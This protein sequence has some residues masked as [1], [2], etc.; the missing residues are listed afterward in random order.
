VASTNPREFLPVRRQ[1]GRQ[2]P[3]GPPSLLD[4]LHLDRDRWL[5]VLFVY[6]V[7][8]TPSWRYVPN[9]ALA[10]ILDVAS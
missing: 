2:E 7:R 6:A 9:R 5:L 10:A 4:A 1:A 3:L 8:Y